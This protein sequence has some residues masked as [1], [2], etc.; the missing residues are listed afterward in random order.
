MQTNP[1]SAIFRAVTMNFLS[2]YRTVAVYTIRV[3]EAPV[4]F[5]VSRQR[6]CFCGLFQFSPSRQICFC[7]RCKI[8]DDVYYK[9]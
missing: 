1:R 2:G 5:R 4:R 8:E 6:V 3:R 9:E 7:L